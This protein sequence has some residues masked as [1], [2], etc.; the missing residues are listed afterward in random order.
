MVKVGIIDS[1]LPAAYGFPVLAAEDFTNTASTIDQLGHGTAI[2][3]IIGGN[4]FVEI[5]SARVFHDKLV[6]SPAQIAEAIQWLISMNVNLI[7]MSFGLRNDRSVLRDSCELA[8]ANKIIVVAAAPSQG[9][10][11]YPSN[12]NGMIRATGDARCQQGE[13]SWLNSSQAD[14]GGYS[15]KPHCGPAGASIGC[16]SVTASI[17][18]I[19][20]QNPHYEQDAI[21]Q[22]LRQK[23]SYQGSQANSKSRVL[24]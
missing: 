19:K 17:T 16:A 4:T 12:Y 22:S 6:C 18:Q 10:P 20:A 8:L 9:E 15:G 13:I 24:L 3:N 11:V 21:M 2:T 7:N 23:S 14:F 1:G 5:V